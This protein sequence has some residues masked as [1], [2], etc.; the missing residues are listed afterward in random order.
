VDGEASRGRGSTGAELFER[1]KPCRSRGQC[2]MWFAHVDVWGAG[3]EV[4]GGRTPSPPTP[5][6]RFT[7]ARGGRWDSE[8]SRGRGST[9]DPR[10]VGLRAVGKV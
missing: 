5:L 10:S 7:G 3:S 9:G 6:P 2:R 1:G 4:S 8:A